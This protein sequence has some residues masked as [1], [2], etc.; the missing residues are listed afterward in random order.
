MPD[1]LG[2]MV[3][4]VAEHLLA[5]RVPEGPDLFLRSL[6]ELVHDDVAL[7]VR[8]HPGVV[9]HENIGIRLPARGEQKGTGG[10]FDHLSAFP[11][12]RR[13]RYDLPGLADLE[14]LGIGM[15]GHA[16][17]KRCLEELRDLRFFVGHEPLVPLDDRDLR[18]HCF[19]EMSELRGNVPAAD[20]DHALG[21]FREPEG[22]LVREVFDAFDAFDGRD[23]RPGAGD[24]EDR[25]AL[26]RPVVHL[27]RM[28]PGKVRLAVSRSRSPR[29]FSGLSRMRSWLFLTV[30]RIRSMIAAKSTSLT[31]AVMPNF[32]ASLISTILSAG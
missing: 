24:E 8:L 5:D 22:A 1:Q 32:F 21:P 2:L 6:E 13:D 17:G 16:P 10:D 31:S 19:E 15:D 28:I 14:C 23:E 18:A 30:D 9:D 4:R 25:L 26:D 3:R 27:E 12:L 29:P 11:L 7:L 20:D